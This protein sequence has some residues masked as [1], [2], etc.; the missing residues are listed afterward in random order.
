MSKLKQSAL[1]VAVL[2]ALAAC[3]GD[4]A[5]NIAPQATNVSLTNIEAREW[6]PVSGSFAA[7]DA[8][9]DTLSLTAISENGTAVAASGGVYKLSK[10]SLVVTGLNF[11]F[12]PTAPGQQL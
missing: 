12:I 11:V 3:G 10:G 6:V 5:K 8:N 1:S 2:V 4:G 9:K 7:S